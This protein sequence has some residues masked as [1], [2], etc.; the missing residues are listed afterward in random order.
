MPSAEDFI[1]IVPSIPLAYGSV[2]SE[3]PIPFDQWT[4]GALV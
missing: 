4:V 1:R 3:K 2:F